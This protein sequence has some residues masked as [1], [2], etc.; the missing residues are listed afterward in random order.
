[1]NTINIRLHVDK[2]FVAVQHIPVDFFAFAALKPGQTGEI[3]HL[4]GDE[5]LT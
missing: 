1:L 2:E 4:I 5:R 3:R